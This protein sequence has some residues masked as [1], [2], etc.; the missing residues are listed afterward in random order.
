M[1][2]RSAASGT[3]GDGQER[4]TGKQAMGY[5]E[6]AQWTTIVPF[7]LSWIVQMYL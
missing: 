1:V 7:M 4:A 2:R 3:P 5:T 6:P